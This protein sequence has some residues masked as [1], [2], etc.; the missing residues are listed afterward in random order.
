M[1]KLENGDPFPTLEAPRV[2]GR[3]MTIPDDLGDQWSLVVFYRGH[4]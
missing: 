3:S 2:S 1:E 4:W